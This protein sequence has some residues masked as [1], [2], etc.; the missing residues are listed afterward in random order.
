MLKNP[1]ENYERIIQIELMEKIEASPYPPDDYYTEVID[2]INADVKRILIKINSVKVENSTRNKAEWLIQSYQEKVDDLAGVL[3]IY[4]DKLGFTIHDYIVSGSWQELIME[5]IESLKEIMSV[6]LSRHPDLF[7]I[8]LDMSDV[9]EAFFIK[10]SIRKLND[11]LKNIQEGSACYEA[12]KLLFLPLEEPAGCFHYTHLFYFNALLKEVSTL[13]QTERE[14]EEHAAQIR[15]MLWNLNFNHP[16]Y[17]SII[18]AEYTAHLG[19]SQGKERVKKCL[20]IRKKVRL[21]KPLSGAHLYYMEPSLD[22]QSETW[23]NTELNCT[24][25]LMAAESIISVNPFADFRVKTK[26]SQ[27]EFAGL[28]RIF[29]EQGIFLHENR[30]ELIRFFANYFVPVSGKHFSL[31]SLTRSYDQYKGDSALRKIKYLF[32][33][34]DI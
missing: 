14:D 6:L 13:L 34:K 12:F 1:F 21:N 28:L 10:G 9:M 16:K 17:I 22:E 27:K 11:N 3:S 7:D 26:L 24:R 30:R 31:A 15:E 5:L 20:E 8:H 4:M 29:Y 25:A 2:Q 18:R 23:L 19:D 33:P 32:D